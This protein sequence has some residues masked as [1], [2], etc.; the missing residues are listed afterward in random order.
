MFLEHLAT[1]GRLEGVGWSMEPMNRLVA[2]LHH[3]KTARYT[4][5][6]EEV[7]GDPDVQEFLGTEGIDIT[8]LEIRMVVASP[9]K[10]A[11][12]YSF[13]FTLNADTLLVSGA[14]LDS[15]HTLVRIAEVQLL[16]DTVHKAFIEY[17]EKQFRR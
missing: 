5:Q 2:E 7:C 9:A 16:N 17:V 12:P 1:Y 10:D 11:D 3:D 8:D 4:F 14:K 6:C 15:N 13:E